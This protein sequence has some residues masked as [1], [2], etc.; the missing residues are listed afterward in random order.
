MREF[1]EA[2]LQALF[3]KSEFVAA[4]AALPKVPS[5]DT[6]TT[7]DEWL[8][9]DHQQSAVICQALGC[10]HIEHHKEQQTLRIAI[11][12]KFARTFGE[13]MRLEG[14]ARVAVK[15]EETAL[16]HQ[17]QEARKCH[18]NFGEGDIPV[19]CYCDERA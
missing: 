10:A 9:I 19:R 16:T 5:D 11:L 18:R 8:P 13:Y 14:D 6:T 1:V 2:D 3:E 4:Y 17:F 12:K 15:A 7:L